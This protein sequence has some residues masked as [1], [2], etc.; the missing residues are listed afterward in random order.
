[1]NGVKFGG[2]AMHRRQFITTGLAVISV[3]LLSSIV[4]AA[5][6]KPITWWYETAAP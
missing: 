6:K 1:M 2:S 3:P 5:D 4:R